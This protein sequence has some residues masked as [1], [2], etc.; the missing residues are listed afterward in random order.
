MNE[1]EVRFI[2]NFNDLSSKDWRNIDN[3]IFES[4]SLDHFDLST[5]R[6]FWRGAYTTEVVKENGSLSLLASAGT[7]KFGMADWSDDNQPLDL[8]Q[9]RKNYWIGLAPCPPPLTGRVGN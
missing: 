9:P 6:E 1:Q 7:I 8:S 3:W 4:D 5:G 2:D